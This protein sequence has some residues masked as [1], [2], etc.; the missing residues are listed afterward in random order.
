MTSNPN[1]KP[2]TLGKMSFG[3]PV[4]VESETKFAYNNNYQLSHKT[5]VDEYIP[6]TVNG[7]Y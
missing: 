2:S 6:K 1:G 4:E 5:A 7:E 3:K